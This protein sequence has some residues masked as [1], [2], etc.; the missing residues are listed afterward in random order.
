VLIKLVAS[1]LVCSLFEGSLLC[2][3]D[4]LSIQVAV[5]QQTGCCPAAWR[6]GEG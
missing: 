5:K 3:A 6:L 2:L 1:V 4:V